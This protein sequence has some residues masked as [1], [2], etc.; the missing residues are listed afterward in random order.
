MKHI[1]TSAATYRLQKEPINTPDEFSSAHAHFHSGDR[2]CEALRKWSIASVFKS[3]G[4]TTVKS[5]LADTSLSIVI[6][7]S[8]SRYAGKSLHW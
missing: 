1:S 5:S 6:A 2:R 8:C 7:F 4:R 3:R